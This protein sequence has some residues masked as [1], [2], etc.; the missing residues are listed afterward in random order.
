[1][2][3][4]RAE[5]FN[6]RQ[7]GAL[8]HLLGIIFETVTHG[9]A[10]AHFQVTASHMAP[11]GYLHAASVVALADSACGYGCVASL[12]DGAAS[13]TTIELKSNHLGT[14]RIGDTV[15][16]QASLAHAGR[17]T[18][19]WDAVVTNAGTGKTMALFRCTQM[20]LYPR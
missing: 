18:Q 4:N 16:C 11:N 2:A 20:V 8:P 5:E 12:P 19:V 1:M 15:A 3:G 7:Q 17:T 13:F 10:S 9:S 6:K 14:A